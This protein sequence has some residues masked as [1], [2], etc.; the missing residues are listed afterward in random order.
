MADPKSLPPAEGPVMEH[1]ELEWELF[2]HRHRSK[3]IGGA[4]AIV[5]A[6]GGAVAW[7]I[8]Q[9]LANDAAQTM[10]ATS[11]D[12]AGWEAVIAKYPRSMSA[13]DAYFR[14][15]SSQRDAGKL[16][17]STA[18]FQKFLA[19]FPEHTLAGGALLGIGQNLETAGKSDEAVASY[20]QVVLTYPKSYAAPVAAYS[21]AEI[22]IR[23]QK[24]DEA[25]RALEALVADF[26]ASHAGQ[27]AQSQLQR[28]ASAPAGN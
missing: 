8:S 24:R 7:S 9:S 21:A 27:L 12:A 3:I 19:I 25:R 15:A 16:D 13:G 10:L 14:L 4:V 22:M 5:V 20:Q 2:W 26:P 1:D 28:L 17:E 11:T 18:T 6:V 23:Q